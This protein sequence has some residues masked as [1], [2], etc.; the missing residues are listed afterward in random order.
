MAIN[1]LPPEEKIKVIDKQIVGRKA[2]CGFLCSL[3]LIV[4]INMFFGIILMSKNS[5][6]ANLEKKYKIYQDLQGDIKK[7]KENIDYSNREFELIDK[8]FS[9]HFYWSEKLLKLSQKVPEEIWFQ[10]LSINN[11][12]DRGVLKIN[13][14]VANINSEER[15]LSILNKFIKTLKNDQTFFNDFSEIRLI[16]VKSASLKNKEGLEFNLELLLKK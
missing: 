16:D 6:V 5:Y 12:K 14:L 1:L 2:L 7:I 13:G 3:A 8:F 15:P 10:R 9:N 4:L 11:D